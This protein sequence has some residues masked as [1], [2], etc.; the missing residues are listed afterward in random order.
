MFFFIFHFLFPLIFFIL[1]YLPPL[2]IIFLIRQ[3]ITV[4]LDLTNLILQNPEAVHIISEDENKLIEFID[5]LIRIIKFYL[6]LMCFNE[7]DEDTD[8]NGKYK[9]LK[10]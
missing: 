3:R 4:A 10:L 7:S 2:F 6:N 8:G 5:V 1:H 9:N